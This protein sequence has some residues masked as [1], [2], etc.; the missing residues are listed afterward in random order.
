MRKT[1]LVCFLAL[2]LAAGLFQTASFSRED[3]E[4]DFTQKNIEYTRDIQ[5]ETGYAY[6]TVV[7]VSP[8]RITL[9]EYNADTGRNEDVTYSIDPSAELDNVGSTREIE[10]GDDV[11]VE[12]NMREGRRNAIYVYVE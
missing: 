1:L 7:G 9:N 3:E 11:R 5:K 4:V 2:M 8:D 12:Y 6:G 10:E